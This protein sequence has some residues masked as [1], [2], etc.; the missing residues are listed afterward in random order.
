MGAVG[1]LLNQAEGNKRPK[2]EKWFLMFIVKGNDFDGETYLTRRIDL[3][4]IKHSIRK[5]VREMQDR[6]QKEADRVSE[7]RDKGI[8]DAGCRI[9]FEGVFVANTDSDLPEYIPK[10]KGY[11]VNKEYSWLIFECKSGMIVKDDEGFSEEISG[12]L[13]KNVE[14]VI[15]KELEKRK[16]RNN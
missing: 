15:T 1:D 13:M 3:N 16:I 2:P 9:N 10:M 5:H 8:I 7:A 6:L 12:A 11:R 14:E 4:D